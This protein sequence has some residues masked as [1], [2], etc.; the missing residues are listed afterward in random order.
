MQK[1]SLVLYGLGY[2]ASDKIKDDWYVNIYPIEMIPNR[3][4]NPVDPEMVNSTTTSYDDEVINVIVDKSKLITAKWINKSDSNRITPPD[5]MKGETVEIWNYAGTDDFRWATLLTEPDLRKHEKVIHF[6][7]NKSEVNSE[8]FQEEGYFL[9]INTYDEE[10]GKRVVLH[11]A[12]NDGEFTTYDLSIETKE[13]KITMIDGL[14][15][16]YQLD[17]RANQLTISTNTAVVVNTKHATVNSDTIDFNT[18][19]YT[20]KSDLTSINP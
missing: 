2:V 8:N 1:S 11:T 15:N 4:N 18:K 17:S 7:S 14:G 12:D 19:T 16:G 5:V 3:S 6:Y 10:G 9:A 20:V 13:G